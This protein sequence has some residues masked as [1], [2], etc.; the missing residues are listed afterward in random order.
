MQRGASIVIFS[1]NNRQRDCETIREIAARLC[2]LGHTI[3]W[4]EADRIVASRRIDQAIARRWPSLAQPAGGP[5]PPLRRLLRAAVKSVMVLGDRQ[6]PAIVLAMLQPHLVLETRELARFIA[7]L[8]PGEVHVIAHSAGAIHATRLAAAPARAPRIGR[9]LCFGYPLR[10]PDRAEEAYRTRHLAQ[11]SR[12]LMVIQGSAD[13]YGGDPALLR[14]ALP[15]HAE[16]LPLACDHDYNDLA[17]AQFGKVWQAARAFLAGE[18]AG[19]GDDTACPHHLRQGQ[20][21]PRPR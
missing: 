19:A 6:G 9:I 4:Y 8:P 20:N 2:E 16:I 18:A 12:P 14:A 11:V 10:H 15:P 13:A 5:L 17:P 3:H 21:Y 7:G 1:R